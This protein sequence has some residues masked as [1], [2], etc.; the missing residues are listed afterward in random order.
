MSERDL[1]RKIYWTAAS[2]AVFILAVLISVIFLNPTS[3]GS[4]D[5]VQNINLWAVIWAFTFVIVLILSFI[6]ARDLI[7]LFF[8]YQ[9]KKPGSRI[10][11]KLVTTFVIFSLF[12]ALIMFFLAFGLINRNLQLWFTSPSE[13]LFGS[14]DR[15]VAQF[16]RAAIDRLFGE[17]EASAVGA[18]F[19]GAAAV[20][21][22]EQ[23]ERVLPETAL[24]PSA[25]IE[26]EN[27]LCAALERGFR[28][29][30]RRP[31]NYAAL[32]D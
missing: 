26:T 24:L 9:A 21:G 14:S 30:L 28:A 32:L 27:L 20:V 19:F 25:E 11:T 8:E 6:L 13:Q 31:G 29:H 12:P 17:V 1:F 10:K 15:I 2:L 18:E 16:Y 7:K 23:N 22:Q 5:F 3:V 4:P